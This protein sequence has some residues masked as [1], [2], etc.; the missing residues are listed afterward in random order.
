MPAL[1]PGASLTYNYTV[2]A[3][4]PNT[5]R[6]DSI[7]T[8]TPVGN[9]QLSTYTDGPTTY[10]IIEIAPNVFQNQTTF[11][12][13]TSTNIKTVGT[14]AFDGCTGLVSVNLS[15]LI[16]LGSTAFKGCTAL[17]TIISLG[18]ITT[19]PDYAFQNCTSLTNGNVNTYTSAAITAI[20]N[21]AF[22]GCTSLTSFSAPSLTAGNLGTAVLSNCT[23]LQGDQINL[24]SIINIPQATFSNCS[25][26]FMII[27]SIS[28]Q[29]ITLIDD[30]AF[31]N[32]SSIVAVIIPAQ[33][34]VAAQIQDFAFENC[35]ILNSVFINA[36]DPPTLGTTPFNGTFATIYYPTSAT[37]SNGTWNAAF[38]IPNTTQ[39]LTVPTNA[40]PPVLYAG[41]SVGLQADGD[42]S[43]DPFNVGILS[44][45]WYVN[46][47]PVSGATSSQYAYPDFTTPTTF[48]VAAIDPLGQSTT[49]PSVTINGLDSTIGVKRVSFIITP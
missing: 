2:I 10:N 21:S 46:S 1:T 45:Q 5:I 23:G 37:G 35:T 39:R 15:A 19:I 34:G 40:N 9:L 44:Y 4:G 17:T 38:P 14:S 30:Y 27:S 43:G 24:G 41:N 13:I 6:I 47:L 22:D 12:S 8:G 16:S 36:N 11:H 32:N 49:S 31:A 7:A 33:A 48:A 3:P 29:N 18:S 42:Q 25:F 20:G 26:E 28:S